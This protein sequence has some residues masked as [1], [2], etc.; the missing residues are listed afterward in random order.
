VQQLTRSIAGFPPRRPEFETGASHVGSMVAIAAL[1]QV[2][3]S[4]S[5]A[6]IHSTNCSTII[7][8]IIIIQV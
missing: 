5:L 8:I 1:G 6:I 4:V 3:T 2:L 7:I